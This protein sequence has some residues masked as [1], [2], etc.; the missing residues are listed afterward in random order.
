M[1]LGPTTSAVVDPVL[2]EWYTGVGLMRALPEL[3]H[4]RFGQRPINF[5]QKSGKRALFRRYESLPVQKAP[6]VEMTTPT[7]MQITKTDIYA[8]LVQYGGYVKYS[9]IVSLTTQDPFLTEK[10]ALVGENAGES[11]DEAQR[12]QLLAT[13]SE[14]L[15]G[16]VST[17]VQIV[18]KAVY[19]DFD[20]INRVLK[21]ARAKFIDDETIRA[22]SGVGTGP[23]R[24]CYYVLITPEVAYD[25]DNTTNF[26]GFK[27]TSEYPD[28]G[29]S[30]LPS[31]LGAYK[32]FRF[33]V[34]DKESI[35]PGLGAAV[36]STGL[37]STGGYIDVNQCLIFARDAYGIVQLSGASYQTLITEPNV[38]SKSD[39]LGQYGT[40]GWKA[41]TTLALLNE[42]FML[43]YEC[44]ATA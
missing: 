41:M 38:A 19:T 42:T 5:P 36:A 14:Y 26:P 31:E 34:S 11:I 33:L 20:K 1:A 30:A 23:I 4:S 8:D 16:G 35:L 10:S 15:A 12:D 21:K 22:N 18:T 17:R 3:N 43:R 39:P 13:T 9:D 25:V 24:P 40:V 27:H 6:L 37:A 7:P 44:G 29:K 28:G 2:N 32:N